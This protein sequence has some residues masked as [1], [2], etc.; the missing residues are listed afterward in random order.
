MRPPG[1]QDSPGK[2]AA[3]RRLWFRRLRL[4]RL[5]S[6]AR[7]AVLCASHGCAGAVERAA[8]VYAL[9]NKR[10]ESAEIVSF[11][12][13]ATREAKAMVL[14]KKERERLD[15]SAKCGVSDECAVA[16]RQATFGRRANACVARATKPLAGPLVG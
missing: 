9:P 5:F 7:H 16:H 6:P 12:T 2:T 8:A 4:G 10:R 1:F 15:D 3:A 11:P 13:R 14:T